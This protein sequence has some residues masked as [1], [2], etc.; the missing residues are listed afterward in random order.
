MLMDKGPVK[1]PNTRAKMSE[2]TFYL[3]RMGPHI[4]EIALQNEEVIEYYLS[5]FLSAGRSATLNL[6][7]EIK[8]DPSLE[9]AYLRTRTDYKEKWGYLLDFF[10]DQRNVA[11]HARPSPLTEV[12]T[13]LTRPDRSVEVFRLFYF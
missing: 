12:Q 3:R 11:I 5:A 2:A 1:L 6:Q 9:A 13:G 8:G 4:N 7:A 10:K